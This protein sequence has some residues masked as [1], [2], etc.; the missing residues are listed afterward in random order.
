M[1][2]DSVKLLYN[3][4]AHFAA[5]EKYPDGLF[6]ELKKPGVESYDAAFWAFAE[7][8]KQAELWRRFMGE[9][10]KKILTEQEW[11]MIIKPAQI[12]T[13]TQKTIEAIMEGLA[14]D[15][16]EDEEVDEVLLEL[17]KKTGKIN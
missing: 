1:K 6:K 13:V 12:T 3:A 16:D 15:K 4:D 8:A 14:E 17:E 2:I 11:R 9:K 7:C 10:P 5:A